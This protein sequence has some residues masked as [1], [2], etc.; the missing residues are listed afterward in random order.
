[1]VGRIGVGASEARAGATGIG[2]LTGTIGMADATRIGR[3]RGSGARCPST[4]PGVSGE[5]FA[6]AALG[7]G[8]V[9]LALLAFFAAFLSADGFATGFTAAALSADLSGVL[10]SAGAPNPST[11]AIAQ[12]KRR[13]WLRLNVIPSRVPWRPRSEPL[14]KF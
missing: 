9:V 12:L 14:P 11:I 13:R 5:P 7:A 1:M 3:G 6:P 10:A 2:A 8:L 4:L